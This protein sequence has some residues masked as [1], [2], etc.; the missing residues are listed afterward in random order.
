MNQILRISASDVAACSGYHPWKSKISLFEKYLY[1]DLDEL[2]RLDAE[3][4]D[5]EMVTEDAVLMSTIKKYY[6]LK[7]N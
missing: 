6:R 2:L 4:L 7:L 3:N 1:Q 5:L